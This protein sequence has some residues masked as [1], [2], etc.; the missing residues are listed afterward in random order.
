MPSPWTLEWFVFECCSILFP[1]LFDPRLSTCWMLSIMTAPILVTAVRF[2]PNVSKWSRLANLPIPDWN[3]KQAVASSLAFWYRPVE[4]PVVL[5]VQRSFQF[6][7]LVHECIQS[8]FR[9][10]LARLSSSPFVVPHLMLL[11]PLVRYSHVARSRLLSLMS[12]FGLLSVS[13]PMVHR[14]P[15]LIRKYPRSP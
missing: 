2:L 4:S 1:P 10:Y 15:R 5:A 13:P 8:P 7:P 6:L 9:S 14:R 11:A 12:L 3:T